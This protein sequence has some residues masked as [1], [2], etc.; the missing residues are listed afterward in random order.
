MCLLG[1]VYHTSSVGRLDKL[2]PLSLQKA[3]RELVT[4]LCQASLR[5]Y[6]V[7]LGPKFQFSNNFPRFFSVTSRQFRD[8]S[9]QKHLIL[10]PITYI[11]PSKSIQPAHPTIGACE[12]SPPPPHV[13][14]PPLGCD[15]PN[16]PQGS[17]PVGFYKP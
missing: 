7:W 6:L 15:P 16:R 17:P 4:H 11:P 8:I 10:R 5:L 12:G 3:T 14:L 9:F 1:R 2:T 13:Q